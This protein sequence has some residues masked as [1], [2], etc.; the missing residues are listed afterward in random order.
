[1][2]LYGITV[3]PLLVARAASTLIVLILISE[4]NYV[5]IFGLL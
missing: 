3:R 2:H 5:I 1:M 4:W